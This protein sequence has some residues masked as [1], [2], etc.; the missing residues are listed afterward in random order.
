MLSPNNAL[1]GSLVDEVDVDFVLAVSSTRTDQVSIAVTAPAG[2]PIGGSLGASN[3]DTSAASRGSTIHIVLKNLATAPLNYVGCYYFINHDY[4]AATAKGCTSTK[5][6]TAAAKPPAAGAKKA[7]E[8][9]GSPL[10]DQ[11]VRRFNRE[12][13]A[14]DA[15]LVVTDANLR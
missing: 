2:S 10:V 4:G 15:R 8:N 3:A 14:N 9:S 5:P 12:L 7:S 1:A 11:A 6:D 13:A